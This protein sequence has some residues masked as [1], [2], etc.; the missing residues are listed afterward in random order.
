MGSTIGDNLPK[1]DP[2]ARQCPQCWGSGRVLLLTSAGP[3]AACGG[4]GNAAGM[5]MPIG[6]VSRKYNERGR[7]VSEE[8]VTE[9]YHFDRRYDAERGLLI[10]ESVTCLDPAWA[11]L[12][13]YSYY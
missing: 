4:T 5:D 2:A 12:R 13:T 10:Q 6:P 11:Q 9:Q 8:W 1:Q 3:C 7:L